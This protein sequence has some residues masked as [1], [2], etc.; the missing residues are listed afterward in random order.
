MNE[1]WRQLIN[2]DQTASLREDVHNLELEKIRPSPYQPRKV[3]L[4]QKLLEL[5]QSIKTYGLLQPVI[6]R[7]N[8]DFYQRKQKATG[9]CWKTFS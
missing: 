2:I 1:P 4:E 6:V 5:A 7:R 8:S 3:F 9:S